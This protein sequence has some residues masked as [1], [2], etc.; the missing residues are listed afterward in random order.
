MVEITHK[1]KSLRVA[2]AQATLTVS[3]QETIDAIVNKLVPKGDVFEMAKTAGLFAVKKTADMIP[4]LPTEESTTNCSLSGVIG[5][6]PGIIGVLQANEVIKNNHGNRRCV[7][8]Q[9]TC[10]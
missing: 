9:T 2:I 1:N 5:V 8:W 7:I 6:L 10:L 4:E 3:K